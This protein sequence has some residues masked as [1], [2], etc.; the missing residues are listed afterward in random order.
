MHNNNENWDV[1]ERISNPI[2][3]Y[4]STSAKREI[5]GQ[6]FAIANDNIYISARLPENQIDLNN[7]TNVGIVYR[8]SEKKPEIRLPGK[9]KLKVNNDM[10]IAGDWQQI[11]VVPFLTVNGVAITQNGGGGGGGTSLTT[12]SDISINAIDAQDASFNSLI[13]NGVTI[14]TNGGGGGTSLTTMK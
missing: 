2:K 1:I 6:A 11:L 9:S 12:T 14:N 4:Y 8:F 13:V 7:A 3:S 5:F 10:L